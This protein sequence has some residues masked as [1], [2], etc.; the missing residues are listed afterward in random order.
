[1]SATKLCPYCDEEIKAAARKCRYCQ[2]MLDDAPAAQPVSQ[3]LVGK[4]IGEYSL[5]RKL[6][7]G[8]MAEVYLGVHEALG[9]QVAIKILNPSLARDAVVRERFIQEARIQIELRHPGIVQVHTAHTKGEH[10]ALVM[11]YVEGRTLADIIG[12]E[13]GPV[14]F[15]RA[16]PL[17]KQ[18][19]SAMAY[20]HE[21]GVIHRD[22][23]PSNILVSGDGV[24]KVM[25]FGIAKVASSAKLTRTGTTLGTAAYMSPEQIKGAKDVDARSDIY[26]LGVTFYEMLAGRTPFEPEGEDASDSDYLIKDAHVHKEPPD[27]RK[28]YPAIPEGVVKVLQKALSKD[29]GERFQSVAEMSSGI[30]RT[31]RKPTAAPHAATVVETAATPLPVVPAAMPS[32]PPPSPPPAHRP[33]APAV[34]PT[35]TSVEIAT[36]KPARS[37]MWVGGAIAATALV[38]LVVILTVVGG[39]IQPVTGVPPSLA[40]QDEPSGKETPEKTA[41]DV[42][43][44]PPRLPAKPPG[45]EQNRQVEKRGARKTAIG[46]VTLI[47]ADTQAFLQPNGGMDI[48]Y[49]LTF[50]DHGSRSSIY[51][52]GPFYEP[53]HFTRALLHEG[54]Q[55]TTASTSSKGGG[56][57]GVTFGDRSTRAGQTYTVELHMR[58]DRRFADPTS[59]AGKELVAVW[60]TPVRWTMPIEESVIKLVLPME[61]PASVKKHEQITSAMVDRLGL[62]T[63]ADNLSTQDRQTYVYTDYQ[64][65]HRLTVFAKRTNLAR[66]GVHLVKVYIP[67]KY[68][69][70]A[71][72][73]QVV[74]QPGPGSVKPR[75]VPPGLADEKKAAK[76]AARMKRARMK[77]RMCCRKI[78][79]FRRICG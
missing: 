10:L 11:E 60:F 77:W 38:L 26:S 16:M 24:V 51:K 3:D 65:K 76:K 13:V 4:V 73:A 20:A 35:Q 14:P 69:P 40:K 36:T 34:K 47:K 37:T 29:S 70:I 50:R 23:K 58:C 67:R 1:M 57:Y 59:R 55:A 12:V 56:Y 63:D 61:L 9:Q 5:T 48:I 45:D 52:V 43:L 30:E 44:G 28:F 71:S 22:I 33:H 78:G 75:L 7:E 49:R 46:P 21:H 39:D 6:G 2:S 17:I 42:D 31:G 19:L 53:V 41:V 15:E 54:G 68:L 72:F 25:D 64:K 74:A 62:M 18:I 8:G 79:L 27:P 32:P 66:W